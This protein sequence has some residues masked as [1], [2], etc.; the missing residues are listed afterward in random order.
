M[1]SLDGGSSDMVRDRLFKYL[2]YGFRC[3]I[4]ARRGIFAAKTPDA[5]RFFAVIYTARGVHIF[6]C[7]EKNF[8]NPLTNAPKDCII[9]LVQ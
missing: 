3:F 6:H 8:K 5:A 4:S 2:S 9:V 1:I 7:P